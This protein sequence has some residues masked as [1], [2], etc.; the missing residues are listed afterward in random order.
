MDIDEYGKLHNFV[1]NYS[2]MVSKLYFLLNS[3]TTAYVEFP[4]MKRR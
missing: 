3:V 2:N 1:T 4:S